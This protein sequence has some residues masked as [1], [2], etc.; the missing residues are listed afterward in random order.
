MKK[1]CL[2][3]LVFVGYQLTAQNVNYKI[4]REGKSEFSKLLINAEVL[5]FD[6]DWGF[7]EGTLAI[8]GTSFFGLTDKIGIEGLARIGYLSMGNVSDGGGGFAYQ[9]EGGAFWTLRESAEKQ[10]VKVIMSQSSKMG[11]NFNTT[12]TEY[13]EYVTD[14][15]T[16]KGLRGGVY[17]KSAIIGSE[18]DVDFSTAYNITGLYYGVQKII[19]YFVEAEVD[20][21]SKYGQHRTRKYID[22]LY[23]PVKT[24]GDETYI[25]ADDESAI[26]WRVGWEEYFKP[27]AGGKFR[28]VVSIEAGSRPFTGFYTLMTFGISL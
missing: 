20:G 23:L 12:S 11:F 5:S 8:G 24:L 7:N 25:N 28:P 3:L 2:F 27:F 1:V 21:D 15:V 19:Q 14:V 17:S 22:L 9:F 18:S 13:F 4:L 26:G 10:A 6:F 16:Q